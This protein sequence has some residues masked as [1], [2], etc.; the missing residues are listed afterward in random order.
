M[1]NFNLDEQNAILLVQPQGKLQASDFLKLGDAVDQY[2]KEHGNL[3]GLI[4]ETEK[5][6][7]WDNI[8]AFKEHVKFIKKHKTFFAKIAL[9]TNSLFAEVVKTLIAP[10]VPPHIK[11]FPY[12]QVEAAKQWILS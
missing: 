12:D 6:P 9:V 8:D 7:G 4:I 3:K 2:V 5:F 11:H 10:F 1:L